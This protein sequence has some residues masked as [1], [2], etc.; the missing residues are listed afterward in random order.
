M[1]RVTTKL[2]VA[3]E[4]HLHA[5]ENLLPAIAQH[6]ARLARYEIPQR[7]HEINARF[8][9]GEIT[10]RGEALEGVAAEQIAL[11]AQDLVTHDQ[12]TEAQD[13]E[14]DEQHHANRPE[15]SVVSHSNRVFLL[16]PGRNPFR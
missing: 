12:G 11:M 9:T 4:H 8:H 2:M 10:E 6:R 5:L 7:M 13:C 1:P 14:N 3:F 16:G 15:R